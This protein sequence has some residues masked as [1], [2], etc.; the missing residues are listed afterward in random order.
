MYRRKLLQ[1]AVAAGTVS[2]VAGIASADQTAT[3]PTVYVGTRDPDDDG[4]LLAVDATTGEKRWTVNGLGTVNSSPT[5]VD[6][7]IYVGSEG[8]P[9]SAID[10]ATGEKRW[11][12][13]RADHAGWSSPT[14]VDGTVYVGA[15]IRTDGVSTDGTILA[16]DAETGTL[17]W[18]APAPEEPF[19]RA[20]PTIVDGTVFLGGA[21][22]TLYA[23]EAPT[24]E[25]IWSTDHSTRLTTSPTVAGGTVFVG[26]ADGTVRALEANSGD[27]VWE[28]SDPGHEVEAEPAVLD[29]D[30]AGHDPNDWTV[31]VGSRD[32]TLYAI[33]ATTG[34]LEWTFE[35]P[36]AW[37]TTAPTAVDGIVYVGSRDKTLYAIDAATGDQTWAATGLNGW[38]Q[39]SPTVF[40]VPSAETTA[41]GADQLVIAGSD[42]GT[43]Y[44][45]D[46][47]D[48]AESWAYERTDASIW[49]SPTVVEEPET[50]SSVG[51]RVQQG[52][53]GHHDEWTATSQ[54]VSFDHDTDRLPGPG[55]QTTTLAV[56]GGLY[57]LWK[58]SMATTAETSGRRIRG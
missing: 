49:S 38:I 33:D 3:G 12:F 55:L 23:L 10:A 21:D 43:L 52:T 27:T 44:A 2:A 29:P 42:D 30:G 54:S 46:T 41:L 15:D 50:G 36:S 13:A 31:Y 8:R 4:A 45:W 18:E 53:L 57:L 1:S 6:G 35:E 25:V 32:E 56:V 19:S 37:V 22:G 48:G 39:S 16:L 14:V 5:V 20:S 24:G 47:A 40:D 34:D 51:S 17:L 28:C 58:Q 7:V 11:S 26:D 9:L